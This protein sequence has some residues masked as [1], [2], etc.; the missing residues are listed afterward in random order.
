MSE[1]DER[2]SARAD[3]QREAETEIAAL[4]HSAAE[5]RREADDYARDLRMAVDAYA[6]KHR[7]DAEEEARRTTAEAEARAASIVESARE[8][9]GRIEHEAR[10]QQ[11]ALR[12]ETHRLEERRREALRG[13]RELVATLEDLVED[14]R[15]DVAPAASLDEALSDRRLLGRRH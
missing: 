8:A 5:A 6:K 9:A 4:T 10:R 11:E 14:A 1:P 3:T 15:V 12:A 2:A 7:Q 13:V